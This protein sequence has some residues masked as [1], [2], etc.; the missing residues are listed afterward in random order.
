MKENWT[1][2]IGYE[3]AYEIS[4]Y[5]RVKSLNRIIKNSRGTTMYIKG[6]ML[7]PNLNDSGYP[8]VCLHYKGKQNTFKVHR[9]VAG[10]FI[11]NPDNL[12][13]V[14]HKDENKLNNFVN[15]LEWCTSR[16]NINYGTRGNRQSKTKGKKVRAIDSNGKVVVSFDVVRKAS[17]YGYS[18]QRISECARGL[19]KTYK[20][21]KWEYF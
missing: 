7:K 18:Y 11:E 12:P 3:G 14:N 9:L 13:E 16:Y 4:T 19:I 17:A 21:L 1:E 10:H 6:K 5:G 8:K 15:N 2:I 20:G